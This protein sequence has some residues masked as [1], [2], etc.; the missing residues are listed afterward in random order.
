MHCI[1]QTISP[2]PLAKMQPK[3]KLSP[4]LLPTYCH[5]LDPKTL[6]LHNILFHWSSFQSLWALAYLISY[7]FWKSGFLSA[8]LPQRPFL[9]KLQ[10]GQ[11]GIPMILPNAELGPCWSLK[12]ETL[13]F[14]KI[15]I[16]LG[17][18]SWA[19]S[20]FLFFLSLTSPHSSNFF[21]TAWI[22]YFGYPV[23]LLISLWECSFGC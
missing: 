4:T 14:Y 12:E 5:W 13:K 6:S 2:T 19:S 9:I 16:R 15:L 21:I 20:S 18:F 3:P 8:T 17:K 22:P 7:L 10:K 23:C 11:L 1:I